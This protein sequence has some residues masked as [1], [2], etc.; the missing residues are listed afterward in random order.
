MTTILRIQNVVINSSSSI[1]VTFTENI[2]QNLVAANVSI[3][4]QTNNVSDSLPILLAVSGSTLT[5]TCQPL[6]PYAAYLLRFQ[7][8]ANNP[9]ISVNGAAKISQDGVSNVFRNYW[10]YSI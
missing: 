3:L 4:S 7:N 8:T 10:A 5:I 2:T 6:I 9:F 1:S